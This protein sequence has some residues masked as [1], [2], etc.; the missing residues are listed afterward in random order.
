[1]KSF[2]DFE[3]DFLNNRRAAEDAIDFGVEVYQNRSDLRTRFRKNFNAYNGIYDPRDIEWVTK[4]TGKLSKVRFVRYKLGRTKIKTL[5]NE[6]AQLPLDHVITTIN[7]EAKN[8]KVQKYLD[9]YGRSIAKPVIDELRQ[10]GMNLYGG[11]PIPSE[12]EFSQQTIENFKLENEIIMN[13]IS[14]FK[15]E[16]ENLKEKLTLNFFH[17]VE[18]SEVFGKVEKGIDGTMVYRPINPENAIFLETD[19]STMLE[20]TPIVGEVRK[21]YFEEIVKEFKLSKE[22][23]E[24]IREY[25]QDP[26]L[27]NG[28]CEK[29][30]NRVLFYVYIFQWRGYKYIREKI[31]KPANSDVP[32]RKILTDQYYN[33]NRKQIDKDIQKGKYEVVSIKDET[34]YQGCRVGS[35]Y[36]GIK[37]NEYVIKQKIGKGIIKTQY[38][39][40]GGVFDSINGTRISLQEIVSEL[41]NSYDTIRWQISREVN[42]LKGSKLLYDLAYIPKKKLLRDVIHEANEDNLIVY[43]TASEGNDF[44][45]DAPNAGNAGIREIKL[46]DGQIL[47]YLINA[48]IDIENLM[49]KVTGINEARQ[50]LE[51]ATTTATTSTNNL[52]SS[53]T[54]TYDYFYF[55]NN[56]EKILLERWIEKTKLNFEE[57]ESGMYDMLLS[58]EQISYMKN[59]KELSFASYGVVMTDGRLSSAVKERLFEVFM[60]EVNSQGVHS[61]DIAKFYMSSSIYEAISIL[62]NAKKRITAAAQQQ[63]AQAEQIQAQQFEQQRQLAMEDRED[64]QQHEKDKII[65]QG[66]INAMN[67]AQ[68]NA[69]EEQLQSKEMAMRKEENRFAML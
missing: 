12:E 44:G 17:N 9:A 54:L 21:M 66:E 52:Q 5:R 36:F 38:D 46:G 32:Y 68:Q 13:I 48:A 33:D 31:S 60:Q 20:R 25:N 18:C 30:K 50:G 26:S 39:Y 69:N 40:I 2:P 51:K 49:D 47:S 64:R 45:L 10:A 34:I 67:N 28:H 19:D 3:A 37:E 57:F 62:D 41:E 61:S 55:I 6:Y 43:N 23:L 15:I 65:L 58:E 35:C 7:P 42:K 8:K 56:Y 11:M 16:R 14:K 59:T 53:R 63:N 1:M 4:S 24:K 29:Y 27:I 22:E